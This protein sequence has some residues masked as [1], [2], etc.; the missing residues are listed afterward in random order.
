MNHIVLKSGATIIAISPEDGYISIN[1]INKG[2]FYT[3]VLDK[4]ENT[5][6][7]QKFAKN[8]T[9]PYGKIEFYHTLQAFDTKYGRMLSGFNFS[10]SAAK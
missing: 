2:C 8:S 3:M 5:V 10:A 7:V 6:E 4:E 1:L 9:N